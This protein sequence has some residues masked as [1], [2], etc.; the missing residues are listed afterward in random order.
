MKIL[1][2]VALSDL[3]PDSISKDLTVSAASKSIDKQLKLIS[4]GIDLPSIYARIDQLTSEQLDHLAASRNFTIWRDTW[5]VD[6]KRSVAKQIIA[7]KARMGTLSAVKLALESL[8][9]A[10]VVKEWWEESPPAE[11]HTFK[12][13]VTLSDIDGTLTSEMQEDC[14]ALLDDAKPVRSHYTFT[15]SIAQKG[16]IQFGS[17]NRP[18]I[19]ARIQSE[20]ESKKASVIFASVAR[21]VIFNQIYN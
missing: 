11:P 6:L 14:F 21:P 20:R 17:V 9:A 13:T 5:P 2:N 3:M 7:Q 15:L 16:G 10:V 12:I 19:F 18:A 1:A 8:G 4:D